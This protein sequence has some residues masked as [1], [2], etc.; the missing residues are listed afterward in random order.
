M[1]IMKII[2][3]TKRKAHQVINSTLSGLQ[4]PVMSPC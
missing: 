2:T 4:D 1:L 3:F